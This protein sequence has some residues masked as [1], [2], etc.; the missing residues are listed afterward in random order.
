V[1]IGQGAV[2][3]GPVL[4]VIGTA[5]A[6]A[7][8]VVPAASH[9][10]TGVFL[11]QAAVA[12]WMLAGRQSLRLRFLLA[13]VAV[14][15]TA[16]AIWWLGLPAHSA[17]V[18]LAGI[19]HA[20]AYTSLLFWFLASLR[21]GREAV[22]TGFARQ[23]RRTMPPEVVRYTRSATA[24]WCVFFAGQLLTSFGLLIAAPETVW[25]AFLTVWNVPLIAA[26][27]LAEF[28][29]RAILFRRHQRTGAVAT[30]MAMRHVRI[31]PGGRS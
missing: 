9:W 24:A 2:L 23:M 6:L 26:M 3:S 28:A 21:A 15:A 25:I 27:A 18:A 22:V 5:G 8:R 17:G 31:R 16:L 29:T 12:A 4:L 14:G 11:V 30:L 10:V 13:A 19:C 7:N 20:I 1:A